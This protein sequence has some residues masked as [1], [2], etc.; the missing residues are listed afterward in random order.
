VHAKA[1][2]EAVPPKIDSLEQVVDM[3]QN[4]G[5]TSEEEEEEEEEEEAS[6]EYEYEEGEEEEE[7]EEGA[8]Y[9]EGEEEEEF[10]REYEKS[11]DSDSAGEEYDGGGEDSGELVEG[12]YDTT[13]RKRLVFKLGSHHNEY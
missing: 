11:Q 5:D 4:R 2:D 7:G 3:F 9:E 1:I 10:E 8:Y 12:G 13:D 6:D